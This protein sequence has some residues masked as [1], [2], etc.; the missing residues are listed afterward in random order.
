MF[1]TRTSKFMKG[2]N[3][4]VL[5]KGCTPFITAAIGLTLM[6]VPPAF[7]D[8]AVKLRVLVITT[9]N[10]MQDPGLAYIKPVLEE[11]GVSY[12][13]LNAGTQDLT[14]T[15]LSSS[16]IGNGCGVE[17]VGCVG[18]YNGIILTDSGLVS[19][20][21]PSEWDVLHDYEKNFHVREAVLSGWPGTYWDP[22]PPWGIYLDYGLTY[23]SSPSVP[24]NA[25][26]AVPVANSKAVFEYVNQVN[27][28]PITPQ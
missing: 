17:V 6:G 10:E 16:L 5:N 7:A 11:M 23:S 9:G 12:D 19:N 15:M 21:T 27:P 24:Y 14:A 1:T 2:V 26:W 22:S 20:F 25:Q 28:L 3:G 18:S 13:L 8:N 4:S